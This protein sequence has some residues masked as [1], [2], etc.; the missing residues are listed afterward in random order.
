MNN[1]NQN[2]FSPLMAALIG[3][4][5]GALVVYLSDDKRRKR[6]MDKIEEVVE[7]G[8]ESGYEFKDK[9]DKSIKSGRKNLAK[10]LRQVE[11]RVAK[12]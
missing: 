5:A 10:K 7:E 12:T 9:L 8:E 4:V 2:D 3:G 11:D 1:N 6:I